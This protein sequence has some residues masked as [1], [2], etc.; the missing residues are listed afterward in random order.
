MYNMDYNTLYEMMKSNFNTNPVME[1]Y[2]AH[3]LKSLKEMKFNFYQIYN[4]GLE[5]K[6]PIDNMT[7]LK[8]IVDTKINSK[9]I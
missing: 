1:R 4:S 2:T 5:L 7:L 3:A 6:V 8:S 9:T